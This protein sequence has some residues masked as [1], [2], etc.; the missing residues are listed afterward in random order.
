MVLDDKERL[1]CMDLRYCTGCRSCEL[2]CSY[3]FERAFCP[4]NSAIKV[5]R[6]NDTGDIDLL[7]NSRCDLCEEEEVPLCVKYCASEALKVSIGAGNII[8]RQA[9]R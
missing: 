2:A 5:M 8:G 4:E 9:I 7:I 3:H 6:N 1:L